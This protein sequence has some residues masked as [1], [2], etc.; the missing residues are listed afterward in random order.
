MKVAV[1]N[2]KGEEP[3]IFEVGGIAGDVGQTIQVLQVGQPINSFYAYE[4]IYEDGVPVFSPLSATNMYVDQLTE[5]TNGDGIPDAPD[6]LINEKDLVV[7]DNQLTVNTTGLERQVP[8]VHVHSL[9]GF[10]KG[11]EWQGEWVMIE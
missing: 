11:L 6:G 3:P 9:Q 5:D 10:L 4:H 1:L 2:I 7:L 8:L